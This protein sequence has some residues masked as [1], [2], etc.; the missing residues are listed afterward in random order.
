[1][2]ENET[3]MATVTGPIDAGLLVESEDGITTLADGVQCA[4]RLTSCDSAIPY[5]HSRCRAARVS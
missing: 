2:N 4:L 3:T 5:R 1:M